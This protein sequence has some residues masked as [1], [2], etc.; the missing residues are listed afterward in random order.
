MYSYN[1]TL[2][3]KP[4]PVD[5]QFLD[6]ATGM[7]NYDKGNNALGCSFN[8]C[9]DG[10]VCEQMAQTS[11]LTDCT[12]ANNTGTGGWAGVTCGRA[13]PRTVTPTAIRSRGSSCWST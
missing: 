5:C 4:A 2:G 10:L 9:D 8:A 11:M 13:R 7:Y 3:T 6:C 1:T 12:A